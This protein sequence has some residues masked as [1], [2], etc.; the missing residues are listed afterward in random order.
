MGRIRQWLGV[1]PPDVP[2]GPAKANDLGISYPYVD[3]GYGGYAD[4]LVEG[5]NGLTTAWSNGVPVLDPGESLSQ[6][7]GGGVGQVQASAIYRTQ[8]EVRKVISFIAM[9]LADIPFNLYE[10]VSDTERQRVTDHDIARLLRRP[11]PNWTRYRWMLHVVSDWLLFDRWAARKTLVPD[12]VHGSRSALLRFP[13]RLV[14]FLGDELDNVIG[15]RVNMLKPNQPQQFVEYTPEQCA[16]DHGYSPAG[17]GGVTP[18]M[19]LQHI[20]AES[21]EAVKWRRQQW[22]N[23]A[24]IPGYVY[25]PAEA[26]TE[27]WGKT[28]RKRVESEFNETYSDAGEKAGHLPFLWDGMEIRQ[29]KMFSA[30]DMQEIAARQLTG[31]EVASAFHIAP[32]LVGAREGTYSNVKEYR[33]ALYQDSGVASLVAALEQALNLALVPEGSDLYIEANIDAKLRGALED[34]LKVYVQATGRPVLTTNEARAMDNRAPVAGG[35][36][37]VT[38]L[39]VTVGGQ[40]SPND[41]AGTG[42]DNEDAGTDDQPEDAP[43]ALAGLGIPQKLHTYLVGKLAAELER[44]APRTDQV[45]RHLYRAAEAAAIF[46]ASAL[47]AGSETDTTPDLD[48]L[49][50]PVRTLSNDTSAGAEQLVAAA[51]RAGRDLAW[52]DYLRKAE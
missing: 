44:E 15:I 31:V 6:L 41:P 32:E 7:I 19:T 10:R 28:T 25:R 43:K 21:F 17:V 5:P 42:A 52:T 14:T 4:L 2:D 35:D 30:Q 27:G 11:Y 22:A 40:P 46:Y 47:M 9:A 23:G 51:V 26:P 16:W 49:A 45:R 29:A 12:E 33:E 38:P 20:L 50:L 37:L 18:M 24:R 36:E 13:S 34:R 48:A 39:N 1:E 3:P 8:P